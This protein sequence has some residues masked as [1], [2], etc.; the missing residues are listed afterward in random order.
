MVLVGCSSGTFTPGA[1]DGGALGDGGPSTEGGSTPAQADGA[2]GTTFPGVGG[3]SGPSQ[4]GGDCRTPAV[5]G[6]IT[7]GCNL[8]LVTPAACEEIDLSGGKSYEFAWTTDGAGCE[9]P[10]TFY[11][12]GNPVT[13]ENTGGVQL[14][15]DT[16][17]GISGTGGVVRVTAA[18]LG[19]L[20]SDNGLYHWTVR[21]FYGSQ[22]PSNAFRIR[23]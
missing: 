10:W 16:S 17:A 2:A 8:R 13:D 23:K 3:D 18:D 6:E 20:K 14:S 5:P 9:T 21:S 22:P 4:A 11:V 19:N 7:G 12:A 15:T 1:G